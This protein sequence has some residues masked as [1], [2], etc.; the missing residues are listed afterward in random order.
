VKRSSIVTLFLIFVACTTSSKNN[1]QIGLKQL[2]SIQLGDNSE[3]I[4]NT[5]GKPSDKREDTAHTQ[6]ELWIYDDKNESQIGAVSLDKKLQIVTSVTAIP[7][8]DEAES[9]LDYL[10]KT[11]FSSS[12][13]EKLPLQR[14]NRHFIPSETFHIDAARGIVVIS[15]ADTKEVESFSRVQTSYATNLIKRIKDCRR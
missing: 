5:L 4:L 13:F 8:E 7:G 10:L 3:K 2:E 15:H 1:L 6:D 12:S 14:C 11:K 9:N